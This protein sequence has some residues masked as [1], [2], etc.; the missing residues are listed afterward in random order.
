MMIILLFSETVTT[1]G[2][3]MINAAWNEC[4]VEW[5]YNMEMIELAMKIDKGTCVKFWSRF[6]DC[7]SQTVNFQE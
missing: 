5:R 6:G 4:S 2:T 3:L 1:Q 7:G